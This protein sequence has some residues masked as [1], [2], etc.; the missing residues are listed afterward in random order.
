MQRVSFVLMVIAAVAVGIMI[1]WIDSR[2]GWDDTGITAGLVI[3]S[4]AVFGALHPTRAWIWALSVGVWI[5][6][7]G[8]LLHGNYGSLLALGVALLGAYA[9]A[10]TRRGLAPPDAP[11][12]H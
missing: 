10:L 12:S 7:T 11:A 3:L 5:P 8:I 2:P 9:G 4:A 1:A 6:L